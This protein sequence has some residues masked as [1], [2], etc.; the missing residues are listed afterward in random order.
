MPS[1]ILHTLFGEDVVTEIYRG[2]GPRLGIAAGKAL[3]KIQGVYRTAF[4]LG[5]QGPDIFY[6]SQMTRPVGLEYGTLLHRRGAGIFTAGL[7][8][9]GLPDLPPDEEDICRGRWDKGISALGV[10]ALGFMTHAILDRQAH[11]YIVYKSVR[12]SPANAETYRSARLHAFFE[13]ILD[14]CMLEHLR[15]EN[16]AD[17]DQE[18]LLAEVCGNPPAGLKD[19]LVRAL[20]LAFPERAG[21]DDKLRI[22]M[23]NVFADCARFYRETAPR[24]TAIAAARALPSPALLAYVYPEKLSGQQ[25]P[26][27]NSAGWIDFL[28]LK[29]APWFY[30]AGDSRE[31]RRSFP[32]VYAGAVEAASQAIAP[33]IAGY[34]ETGSFP[35][36]E[37]AQAIGNGGLSIRD[38]DGRPCAP[39]RSDP[40]P[41][42]KVLE[43]QEKLRQDA[44]SR[45]LQSLAGVQ[46]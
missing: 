11:P 30:P 33:V 43:E 39:T 12:V 21:K 17:W 9:M 1:Q 10:Y 5:C 38:A 28:N 45:T 41:L 23:D 8:K 46:N 44:A 14:V 19:L 20:I 26:A 36:R 40:L 6:H 27:H 31:D 4:V 32:E 24:R 42:E 15:G 3:E 18:G 34:L 25:V 29:N 16:A 37:A 35:I 7:L 22:R 2:L 13:R